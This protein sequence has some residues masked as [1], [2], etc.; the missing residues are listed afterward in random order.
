MI[1][2]LNPKNEFKN[3]FFGFFLMT[4][5]IEYDRDVSRDNAPSVDISCDWSSGKY[6]TIL[7]VAGDHR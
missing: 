3:L 1:K 7:D 5:H 6:L 2:S 4:S